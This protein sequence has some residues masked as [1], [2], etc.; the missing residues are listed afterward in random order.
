[1]VAYKQKYGMFPHLNERDETLGMD[2]FLEEI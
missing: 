1:M 2:G